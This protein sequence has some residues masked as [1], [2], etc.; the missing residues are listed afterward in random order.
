MSFNEIKYFFED[1]FGSE[2][3]REQKISRDFNKAVNER[4]KKRHEQFKIELAKKAKMVKQ[5]KMDKMI[6][7]DLIEDN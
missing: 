5:A 6:R 4:Q 3:T 2:L 7:N 1:L